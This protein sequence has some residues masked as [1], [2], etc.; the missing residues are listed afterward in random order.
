MDQRLRRAAKPDFIGAKSTTSQRPTLNAS[1]TSTRWNFPPTTC[2]PLWLT[3]NLRDATTIPPYRPYYAGVTIGSDPLECAEPDNK[4][5]IHRQFLNFL[6]ICENDTVEVCI[7]DAL[8]FD[9]DG[10]LALRMD[11]RVGHTEQA[12]IDAIGQVGGN[13]ATG[14]FS[15]NL[16]LTLTAEDTMRLVF[17]PLT[18]LTNLPAVDGLPL[19][20]LLR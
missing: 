17:D 18:C 6:S 19:S 1:S 20:G 3:W 16:F 4:D 8:T 14:R 9:V 13:S 7:I 2:G 10:P 15:G 5:S 12:V 11:E